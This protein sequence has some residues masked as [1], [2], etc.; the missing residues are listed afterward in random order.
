MAWDFIKK[1]MGS[2]VE[3]EA[4]AT[5]PPAK[6]PPA[7]QPR[8]QGFGRALPRQPAKASSNADQTDAMIARMV[9][10]SQQQAVA[11]QNART[12]KFRAHVARPVPPITE[13]ARSEVRR[14][15][16]AKLAIRHVFPP[17]LP[18]RSLSFLGG[19]PVVPTDDSFD[20]PMVHNREG[21]LERLNFMAQIDCSDIP[22]GP[23]RNLL[24]NSGYLYFFAPMSLE[25]GPD[26]QHFVTRY[27]P[28]PAR[29]SWQPDTYLAVGKIANL[30]ED[31][32]ALRGTNCAYPKVEIEL[33]WL[34][35]PS[36]AD[37]EARRAEGLPH[38]VAAKIHIERADAFLGPKRFSERQLIVSG[39]GNA[40]WLLEEDFPT[41]RAM[42]R[43]LRDRISSHCAAQNKILDQQ[44]AALAAAAEDDPAFAV[45]TERKSAI[46]ALNERSSKAF[47]GT[48][49]NQSNTVAALTED[50][51]TRANIFLREIL[52]EG[53]LVWAEGAERPHWRDKQ[54]IHGWMALAAVKGA[55]AALM[56]EP[57]PE[58]APIPPA[59]I[60][61]LALRHDA[62][63]HHSF[64]NGIVVQVAADEMKER[65]IL[66]LQLGLDAEMD[67]LVGEMGPLQYWITPED[68][69]ACRFENT[70]LTIE[71]Y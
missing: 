1:I 9:E 55:Q 39:G 43:T 7:T 71:A 24:P 10:E 31:V 56:R 68:L 19:S 64:G 66:L 51:R 49:W 42:A 13:A 45:I 32:I 3:G 11:A 4:R 36:D 8:Q 44:R 16:D 63:Q 48:D 58:V 60:D 50:Q 41:N 2:A 5:K 20:W 57:A 25:F 6:Q 62:R 69:A 37:V 17:R 27:L 23:A 22:S 59:I 30:S 54:V 26:A 53:G 61:A 38:E 21:L 33:G 70:V 40:D 35:E 12:A 14:A 28:G 67:W 65:Y 18:Q 46:S 29:K 47:A 52:E 34:E 15:Q